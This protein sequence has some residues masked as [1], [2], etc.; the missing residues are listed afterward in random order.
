MFPGKM[1]VSGQFT[2]YFDSVTLRDAFVNETE[3]ELV[4]AF[5]TDNTATSEFITVVVPRI[6]LGS[7]DKDDGDGGLVQTFQFQALYNANGG[8]GIKTEKTT[9]SMQDSAA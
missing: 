9:F 7:S 4:A 5:T 6:K 8:T 1:N 2:A 3:I